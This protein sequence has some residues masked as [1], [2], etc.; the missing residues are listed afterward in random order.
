MEK[1]TS[2]AI[3]NQ[4][5]NTSSLIDGSLIA[6]SFKSI[7]DGLCDIVTQ[8]LQEIANV[9]NSISNLTPIDKSNTSVNEIRK[10]VQDMKKFFSFIFNNF[11][12][13]LSFIVLKINQNY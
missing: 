6:D 13:F 1:I 9:K 5:K 12:L 10:Q 11:G 4:L 7:L 2:V 3:I 8:Q